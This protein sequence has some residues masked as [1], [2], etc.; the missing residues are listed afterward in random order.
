MKE[1][2]KEVIL[3]HIDVDILNGFF[4]SYYSKKTH[5]IHPKNKL[6]LTLTHQQEMFFLSP[7][8]FRG[9]CQAKSQNVIEAAHT[10]LKNGIP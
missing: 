5:A 2:R 7:F 1:F 9:Y 8:L 10:Y 3:L 4:D 6:K